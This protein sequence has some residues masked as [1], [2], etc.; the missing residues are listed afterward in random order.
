M[1]DVRWYI[2]I[3][4]LHD[5][6]VRAI[7]ESHDEDL[8][9]VLD[10]GDPLQP[11]DR[12]GDDG[13]WDEPA[14]CGQRD[15]DDCASQQESQILRK[16]HHAREENEGVARQ[17]ANDEECEKREEGFAFAP[18]WVRERHHGLGDGC[19]HQ[20]GQSQHP[21]FQQEL[22]DRVHPGWVQGQSRFGCEDTLVEKERGDLRE[23][24]QE[25]ALRQEQT[26]SHHI[27]RLLV[28]RGRIVI[29]IA[30]VPEDQAHRQG[31]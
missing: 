25:A 26:S 1:G 8:E 9:G 21:G 15:G 23:W 10:G 31:C 12:F 28:H 16:C 5:R 19:L 20:R 3:Q 27:P 24:E 14:G 30:D 7:E 6:R 17:S 22:R 4:S 2:Q 18:G 13:E 29:Y 11:A